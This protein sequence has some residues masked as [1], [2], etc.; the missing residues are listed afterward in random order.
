MRRP[1][2]SAGT[3]RPAE[4]CQL[5]Q[6]RSL[7]LDGNDGLRTRDE[8][9]LAFLRHLVKKGRARKSSDVARGQRRGA[10]GERRSRRRGRLTLREV[11]SAPAERLDVPDVGATANAR[12][13]A[14]TKAVH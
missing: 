12:R 8:R 10:A 11:Y 2:H 5:K 3:C 13:H 9:T 7:W 14:S 6:L 1:L 4:I